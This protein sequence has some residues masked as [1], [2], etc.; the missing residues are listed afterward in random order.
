MRPMRHVR[1]KQQTGSVCR[2]QQEPVSM[3][4]LLPAAWTAS[5]GHG[6]QREK[7]GE[8]ILAP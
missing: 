1:Q 6:G 7:E 8:E 2:R 5:R 3:G 4:P